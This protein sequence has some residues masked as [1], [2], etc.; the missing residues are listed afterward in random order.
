MEGKKQQL[1]PRNPPDGSLRASSGDGCTSR[2][3]ALCS[4]LLTLFCFL[5]QREIFNEVSE[6]LLSVFFQCFSAYQPSWQNWLALYQ[7]ISIMSSHIK[8]PEVGFYDFPNI[9]GPL[10]NTVRMFSLGHLH[11]SWTEKGRICNISEKINIM[12]VLSCLIPTQKM[13]FLEVVGKSYWSSRNLITYSYLQVSESILLCAIVAW[14]HI[15][16][17][18]YNRCDLE[19]TYF[20]SS[21]S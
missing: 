2:N 17:K 10:Q 8:R 16:L 3:R 12:F 5:I 6:D 7:S 11:S 4:H 13:F 21:R 15:F 14:M 9:I 20:F 18:T 19:L 1:C